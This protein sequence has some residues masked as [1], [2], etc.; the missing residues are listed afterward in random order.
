MVLAGVA[1]VI[2]IAGLGVFVQ[3]A[4]R[5][6]A[7]P[8]AATAP[9]VALP[10]AT[11]VGQAGC[12]DCHRAQTA[13]WKASQHAQAMMHATAAA[14]RGNFDNAK[15][16]YQGVTSTF[17]RR[18]GKYFVRTDGPDGKLADFEIRYTFGIE[19]LQQYL[20]ELPGGRLQGLTIAWDSRAKGEGGQRWFSL[21]P[22][23]KIDFRDP[24]HWTRLEQNWNSRCADCHSTNLVRNYDV[25]T[26]EYTTTWSDLNVACEACHGAGSNHVAWAQKK[27]GTEAWSD[28]KGLAI[29]L[30]E[31]RGVNWTPDPATGNATRSKPRSSQ[32]E[33]DTCAVCH[34]S[35]STI[36]R[37]PGPTGRIGDTQDVALLHD[38]LYFPDGQQQGEVYNYASF[39]QS[40][41]HARGV[42]CSDCHDP[43]SGKLRADGNAV[44]A[45]CHAPSKYDA[46]AHTLHPPGSAGAQCAA[47]HMPTRTYMVVDPRHDHSMR[48]PRPDHSVALGTPN[49]CND[50][51]RNQDA[52]WAAAAI[53]RAHGPQRKGYQ[54]FGGAL[55]AGR[56]GAPDA[57]A[58]L[59]IVALDLSTPGIARATAIALL[60][61]YP[62]QET[63]ALLERAT[64]DADPLVRG[65]ALD[66][67]VGLPPEYRVRI[68]D[69]LATDPVLAVR[70]KAGRALASVS[71]EGASEE[72][73]SRRVKAM[74][75]YVATQQAEADRPGA[76]LNLGL[77]HADRQERIEAERE[78]RTAIRLQPDFVPAYANLAD[79]YRAQAREAD[80][81]V[82][83]T[84]GLKAAPG[85][86]ALLH[87][88][89]L[90]RVREK[91]TAEALDLLKRASL[92]QPQNARYAY[93]YGVAL[94][95]TGRTPDALI[96]MQRALE[97]SPNDPD[98]L[99]GLALF[100]RELGRT[101][102]VRKYVEH[103]AAV[104]PHDPRA[105]EIGQ[106]TQSR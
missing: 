104:A 3:W 29:V 27:P 56:T 33:L 39:L 47:C 71:N 5:P 54:A 6:S 59:R 10:A 11:Y 16:T 81:G 7:T 50:C 35:R 21:Y 53:A 105:R 31:R 13:A 106:L 78:Y 82:V 61:R 44:C 12:A 60:Q 25:A 66:A 32:R 90:L 34:G 36:T 92:A 43:H 57:A 37:H 4:S 20:V 58:L 24:L 38:P 41:M 99:S 62:S 18:E 91:K 30:D 95:S 65:A 98:L 14:V 51:H 87:A 22:N 80:A 49:A 9:A 26:G 102:D 94:Q 64:Q 28:T 1:A 88:L 23:D 42:T 85:T 100:S 96:V 103:F 97:R 67:A 75:D 2:A 73:K 74:A 68:G 79:L 89:G 19:P 15:F 52:A 70:A 45:Q 76:H 72:T 8:P 101:D 93:V 40:K 69:K 46:T 86:P 83:L 55:Q 48:I 77:F 17:F 63:M 84:E